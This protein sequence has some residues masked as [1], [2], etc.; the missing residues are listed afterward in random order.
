MNFCY[1][2]FQIRKSNFK[3]SQKEQRNIEH[4]I[5]IHMFAFDLIKISVP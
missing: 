4:E 2:Y 1:E 5:N 3:Y